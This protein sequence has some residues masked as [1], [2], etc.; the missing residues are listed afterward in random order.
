[1][2][3]CKDCEIAVA[4]SQFRCRDV[5]NSKFYMYV[6]NNPC[7]ESS[8]TIE[9]APYNFAYPLLDKHCQ[10]AGYAKIEENHWDLVHDFTER[11]DGKKNY[12]IIEPKDWKVEKAKMMIIENKTEQPVQAIPVPVRYGGTIPDDAYFG[13]DKEEGMQAFDIRNTS[14]KA[15]QDAFEKAKE[16]IEGTSKTAVEDAKYPP[17]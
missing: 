6:A 8:N 7:I 9:I 16:K 15:A 4:C 2:R 17:P 12:S 10:K 14:A 11:D 5:F 1:M 13:E 3:D